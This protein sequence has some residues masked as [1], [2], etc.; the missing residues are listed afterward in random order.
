MVLLRREIQ[1]KV[2][3]KFHY[4]TSGSHQPTIFSPKLNTVKTKESYSASTAEFEQMTFPY[5][6]YSQYKSFH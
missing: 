5:G 3:P 2:I 4:K 6:N 1:F